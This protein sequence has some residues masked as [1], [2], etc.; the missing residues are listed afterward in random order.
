M[1]GGNIVGNP[2]N[3]NTCYLCSFLGVRE[4]SEKLHRR[5]TYHC[6]YDGDDI[7]KIYKPTD[8][9]YFNYNNGERNL[10]EYMVFPK[11]SIVSGGLVSLGK[12]R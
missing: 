5:R 8:C 10:C 3:A 11:L 1:E 9:P 4:S 2:F 6:G 7:L 12:R